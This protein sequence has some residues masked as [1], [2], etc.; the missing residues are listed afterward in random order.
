VA[1]GNEGRDV[2]GAGSG[3]AIRRAITAAGEARPATILFAAAAAASGAVLLLLGSRLTFL[4]DDWEFL[5]YRRGFTADAILAP[6]GE[7]IAVGP[8]LVYK[9][10]LAALGMDSA[11]PFRVVS[12][13]A[14]IASVAVLFVYLRRRIGEWPALAGAVAVL[15]LG[16]AW[17]DLLWPFQIGYFVSMGAGLGALLALERADRRGDLAAGALLTVSVLF[18]SLGLPFLAGAAVAIA[19]GPRSSW[20]GRSFVV[21]VPA[22]VFALWWLG[23]GHAAESAISGE[24]IATAPLFLFDGF[25]SS[26]SSLLGLATPRDEVAV[27]ALDWGRPLLVAAVASCA[28]IFWTRRRVSGWLVVVGVIA[29][30]FWLLAGINEKP[31]RDPLVSR[32]QYVGAIFVLLIAAELFRGGRLGRSGLAAVFAITVLAVASNLSYLDQSYRVYKQ[33]SEIERADLAALEIARGAVAPSF[34]LS[35]ELAHTAYVRI[36]AGP[37]FSAVDAFGSPAYSE[38]ELAAAPEPARQAADSVLASALGLRV[39]AV[40]PPGDGG[41]VAVAPPAGGGGTVIDLPPGGAVVDAPPEAPAT[42]RLRRFATLFSIGAGR[43][44]PGGAEAIEIPSDGSQQP[45]QL[46]LRSA[47]VARVCGVGAK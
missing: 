14:F 11:F 47:G 37:Y 43:L 23:W 25:A 16:A 33:T 5:V 21:A 20:Y 10:L 15:F 28:W 17:E 29:A 27:G 2:P 13:A 42:L 41:C 30:A 39:R 7:N 32:Y 38:A 45:W 24:N 44:E 22:A 36:E 4:L 3:S 12:V 40:R 1:T 46:E 9:G 35:E 26:L 31:G 19:I 34:V 8:V 6:H 18:S